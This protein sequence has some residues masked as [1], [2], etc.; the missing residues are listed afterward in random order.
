MRYIYLR[1]FLTEV[2]LP[3]LLVR[4]G[5][6]EERVSREDHLM[7]VF[8]RKWEFTH[9]G[10]DLIYLPVQRGEFDSENVIFGRIGKRVR[11]VENA[12]PDEEFEALERLGW[13]ASNL[14]FDTRSSSDGQRVAVE[15]RGDVGKPLAIMNS[16]IGHLN[17]I[18][19]DS[20]WFLSVNA[21]IEQRSFWE[22]AEKYKGQVTRA[23]FTY[24]TPNVLGIRSMINERLTEYR[25]KENA[26]SVTVVLNEPK[27]NLK[28]DSQEVK[29]A[30]EY[31]SEGGGSSKL[32]VGR[33][34]VFDSEDTERAKDFEASSNDLDLAT[35]E[36]R[37]DLA[38]RLLR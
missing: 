36:S 26:Q 30:V 12:G 37:A 2:E 7:D 13:R 22:A 4:T 6:L 33:D 11:N 23:E 21:M 19:P 10:S 29:D 24:I 17:E 25:E 15:E 16:L 34:T 20:G 32:K 31:T 38:N 14:V 35:P 27:G 9:R 18:L 3:P 5:D 28:L 1:M 8:N